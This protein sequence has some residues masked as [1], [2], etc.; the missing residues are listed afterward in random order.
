MNIS[1]SRVLGKFSGSKCVL[2]YQS[3]GVTQPKGPNTRAGGGEPVTG[4][5]NNTVEKTR[6]GS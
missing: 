1:P 5:S 2:Y 3:R 4:G 6:A